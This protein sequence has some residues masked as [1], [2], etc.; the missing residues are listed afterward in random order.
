MTAFP[1]AQGVKDTRTAMAKYT[2]ADMYTFVDHLKA[3]PGMAEDFAQAIRTLAR[4]AE[5]LPSRDPDAPGNTVVDLIDSMAAVGVSMARVADLVHPGAR[6]A[7][8]RD[9]ARREAP[10]PE[11]KLW[12][13]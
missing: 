2:P 13:V 11:E 9:L 5:K 6:R 7:L 12:N 4:I 1:P 10:R 3:L 8:A